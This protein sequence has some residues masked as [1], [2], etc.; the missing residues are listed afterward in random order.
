MRRGLFV[1]CLIDFSLAWLPRLDF[2]GRAM[3]FRWQRNGPGHRGDDDPG[4]NTNSEGTEAMMFEVM[5]SALTLIGYIVPQVLW[6]IR[7]GR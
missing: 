6:A 7:R 1:V 2:A 3:Q 5:L 4:L